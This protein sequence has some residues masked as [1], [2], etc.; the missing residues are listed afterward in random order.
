MIGRSFP[1]S[2]NAPIWISC[3]RLGSTTNQTACTSCAFASSNEGRGLTTETS[4]PPSL[5]TCQERCMQG[6]AAY[7][8]KDEVDIMNHVLEARGGVIDELIG[9]QFVQE[10]TI[11]CRGGRNDMCACPSSQLDGEDANAA[12]TSMDQ[13]GLPRDQARVFKKGLPGCQGGQLNRCGLHIVE[14]AWFGSQFAREGNGV[15]SFGAVS[16]IV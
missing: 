6:V 12:R 3:S 11:A 16:T 15:V 5:I 13:G 8:I 1:A 7:Q 2:M 10:I 14:R 9:S 4:V